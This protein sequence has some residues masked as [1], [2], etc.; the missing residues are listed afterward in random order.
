ME[1]LVLSDPQRLRATVP[2]R[3]QAVV[4]GGLV[5]SLAGGCKGADSAP[6]DPGDTPGLAIVSGNAQSGITGEEL[7]NPLVVR[8]TTDTGEPVTGAEVIWAVTTGG[9]SVDPVE[10]STDGAGEMQ[11][12]WVL[13]GTLGEQTLVVTARG[14]TTVFRATAADSKVPATIVPVGG[15]NQSGAIGSQL[16]SPLI[17]RV[18]N[19]FGRPVQGAEVEWSIESGGGTISPSTTTTDTDGRAQA[20]WN[21]GFSA[22]QQTAV[23]ALGGLNN[24]FRATA[25]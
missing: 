16:V 24:R 2:S 12:R 3:F 8:V 4:I 19:E 6:T 10:V 23:A 18:E 17:V 20:Q 14:A 1:T 15:E 7:K 22:G 9:G 25:R 21:L 11:A 13:G 5:L